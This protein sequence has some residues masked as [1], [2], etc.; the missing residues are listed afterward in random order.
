MTKRTLTTEQRAAAVAYFLSI[1]DD[2]GIFDGGY[3]WRKLAEIGG[4][5]GDRPAGMYASLAVFDDLRASG[6]LHD[7]PSTPGTFG[8]S[9]YR[10]TA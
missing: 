3:S 9:V 5:S 6:H 1:A 8:H 10:I 7:L 2:D 4:S